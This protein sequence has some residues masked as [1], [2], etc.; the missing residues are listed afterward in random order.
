M[1]N[2]FIKKLAFIGFILFLFFLFG[3]NKI[4]QNEKRK[5]RANIT[6]E[7]K[8]SSFT[9]ESYFLTAESFIFSLE[10]TIKDQLNLENSTH[11]SLSTY[12]F[13]KDT[14]LSKIDNIEGIRETKQSSLTAIGDPKE[15]SKSKIKEINSV[16]HLKP[17][18]KAAIKAL[19]DLK[20]I[21]Y[22]SRNN[23]IYISPNYNYKDEKSFFSQ[24]K[25][26]FWQ[27]AIPKNNP[28]DK[29]IMTD[30]YKNGE[31]K[32]LLTTLSKP[33]YLEGEFKGV[34]SID[35]GLNTLNKLLPRT[36]QKGKTY[37]IDEKKQIV[38]SKGKFELKKCLECE[39]D[40]SIEIEIIDN[41]L[42]IVHIIDKNSLRKGALNNS[43]KKIVILFLLLLITFIVV[44]LIDLLNKVQ[45]YANTDPLTGL[46]NRRS[47]QREIEKLITVSKRRE[48]KLSFLL[49]D[50]DFF[51][52]INDNYGH[53]MGDKV[54]VEIS[55]LFKNNTRKVDV[56]ARFGGEEFFIALV[57]TDLNEA[58][59]L[60]ERIRITI[61][62][63]KIDSEDLSFTISIGCTSLREQDSF[64]SILKRVD[65]LLYK[66]KD[67]GR[68]KT[69]KEEK[70]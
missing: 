52:K 59:T 68:N 53:Q 31:K 57:N 56:V 13:N 17:L 12:K 15:F 34:V 42:Y 70:I 11:P 55:K 4:Y 47:M 49:L 27:E 3:T 45:F 39:E 62:K 64:F 36:I 67:S 32:D 5:I 10:N 51:K 61:S 48:Q 20:W 35:I 26:P 33:V 29:L 50:V 37:L 69:V 54:L 63:L 14:N 18:F 58:Y 43:S 19:P 1:D 21:Y 46:L 7:L 65:D 40:T 9:I 44:Y 8:N 30:F 23:F 6:N 16:L 25:H 22:T 38:A 24:Y 41:E 28:L 66:A 2:F 60:A